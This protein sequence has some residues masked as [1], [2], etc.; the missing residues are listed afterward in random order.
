MDMMMIKDGRGARDTGGNQSLQQRCPKCLEHR[1]EVRISGQTYGIDNGIGLQIRSGDYDG[2]T[3][4]K[5]FNISDDDRT[6]DNV[7]V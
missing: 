1:N 7:G 4:G 5:S 3:F 6:G 2:V